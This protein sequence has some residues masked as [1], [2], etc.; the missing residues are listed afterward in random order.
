M[1]KI[2]ILL[3]P[4]FFLT[5]CYDYRELSDLAI[6]TAVSI[7]KVDDN[8]EV[9][10][11][12]V[13]PKKEQDTTS[14]NEPD[15]VTYTSYAKTVQEA[16]RK[17][18]NDSPAK[19][20]ASHMELLVISEEVAKNYLN[21]I[22][23]FFSRDLEPRSE[24]NIFIAKNANPKDELS[25]ITP[26]I[27]LPSTKIL[28]SL[29]SNVEYLGT[30]QDITLN[31]VVDNYLNPYKELTLPILELKGDVNEGEKKDNTSNV[32][33][34]ASLVLSN[35][36]IFKDNKFITY[37]SEKESQGINFILNNINSTI[38]KYECESNKYLV[39]EI[40]KSNT[41]LKANL[42]KNIVEINLEGDATISEIT[43]NVDI[44]NVNTVKNI[45]ENIDSTIEN[46]VEETF[47]NIRDKYN[48]DVFNFRDLYYKT[49]FKY[50]KE[51]YKDNWYNETFPKLEIEVNAN[52]KLYEKGSTLGG[53]NYEQK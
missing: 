1:R 24:I 42:E 37:L 16:L 51:N 26:L 46:I 33:T 5:G 30:S 35:I 13:N 10:I 53:I 9:T 36:G 34:E 44:K 21:E 4:I 40:L 11:Q 28:S 39:S 7:D 19:L 17:V 27:N 20:Y 32:E 25:V 8:L 43:C 23:D 6:I 49:D 50:F 2:I 38:I 45:K 22:L 3:I 41:S 29:K 14:T 31:Y 12:V 15:F 18:V 48:T 52:Y 47:Y